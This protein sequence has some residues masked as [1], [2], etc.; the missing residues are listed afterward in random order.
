MGNVSDSRLTTRL[1]ASPIG[2]ACDAVIADR[3]PTSPFPLFSYFFGYDFYFF[4]TF[5]EREKE[6]ERERERVLA[7]WFPLLFY[8]LSPL[9]PPLP[10]SLFSVSSGSLSFSLFLY[11]S[12]GLLPFFPRSFFFPQ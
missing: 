8:S 12:V 5:I 6:R 2:A 1:I 11:L 9:P 4:C 7:R 10:P 3:A